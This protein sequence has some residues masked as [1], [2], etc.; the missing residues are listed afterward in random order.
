MLNTHSAAGPPRRARLA[1]LLGTLVAVLSAGILIPAHQASAHDQILASDPAPNATLTA[2][3]DKITLTFSATI[4]EVGT[5][6]LVTDASGT[7]WAEGEP[8]SAGVVA[9]VPVRPGMPNGALTI[10]WRVVSS[11]GHPISGTIPFTLDAPA[12][13]GTEGSAAPSAP[14]VVTPQESA[15]PQPSATAS[16]ES[17]VSAE[18][19]GSFG[20]DSPLRYVVIGIGGALVA[21]IIFLVVRLIITR[22]RPDNTTSDDPISTKENNS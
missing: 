9:T 16:P 21:T 1:L 12:T 5:K 11:D 7:D 15:A 17:T 3:P 14:A 10:A 2:A 4:L 13:G 18:D 6:V 22:K 8:T 19:G 20:P